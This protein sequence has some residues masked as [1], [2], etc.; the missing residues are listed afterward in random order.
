MIKAITKFKELV[1]HEKTRIES[2]FPLI[3]VFGGDVE[4]KTADGINKYSSCRHVFVQWAHDTKYELAN[5]LHTPEKIPEWNH[6]E[7]NYNLVDFEKDAGCLSNGILLFL[8]GPGALAEL[9]A[10]CTD[11]ILC[12]RLLVVLSQEHYDADS[13]I[14]LGPIKRI[15]DKHTDGS[16]CVVPTT[17]DA[18]A[19]EKEVVG[20]GESLRKKVKTLPKKTMQF[21]ADGKRDQFLLIADLIELFGALDEDELGVLLKF[22]KVNPPN[23]KRMLK[24]LVLFGLIIK[25]TGY[26]D[27]FYVPPKQRNKFLNYTATAGL[28]FEKAPFWLTRVLPVLKE[29]KNKN[30]L[31]AYEKIHGA[32]SWK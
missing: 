20:V 12:E 4:G 26:T 1:A 32:L 23:L 16:I 5:L 11:E 24:Q 6:F 28:K 8:E 21:N 22:M 13:F 19:F 25:S 10:F 27:R 30:R 31:I 17:K 18:H 14:S 3:L 2:L 7:E 15:V 29:D 9:G